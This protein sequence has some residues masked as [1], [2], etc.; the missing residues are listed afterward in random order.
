MISPKIIFLVVQWANFAAIHPWCGNNV[1][2]M[3]YRS[4]YGCAAIDVT[5]CRK[6][7]VHLCKMKMHKY[8][9]KQQ[10]TDFK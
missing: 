1:Y 9:S 5:A 6:D 7:L 4:L 10:L 2:V 8:K 3:L